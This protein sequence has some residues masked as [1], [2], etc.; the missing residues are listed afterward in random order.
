MCVL[1]NI[2]GVH[3]NQSEAKRKQLQMYSYIIGLIVALLLGGILGSNGT[4]YLTA[5]VAGIFLFVILSSAGMGDAFGRLLRS[6]RSK[7]QY[8]DAGELRKCAVLIQLPAGAAGFILALVFSGVLTE[9]V[10]QVPYAVLPMRILSPV[11]FFSA[12][13]VLL[14]GYFQG[15]GALMPSVTVNFL[16]PVFYLSF[17]YLFGRLLSG[18]GEKVSALLNN[19]DFVGMWGTIGISVGVVVSEFLLL[20]FL[21]LVYLG[22]NRKV[23]REKS[24]EGLQKTMGTAV[25]VRM[26][27]LMRLVPCLILFILLLF[28]AFG[29]G[30][31]ERNAEDIFSAA[32][33]YGNYITGYILLCGIPLFLLLGRLLPVCGRLEALARKKDYKAI[34]EL[35]QAIYHYGWIFC[36]YVTILFVIMSS[37]LAGMLF[38]DTAEQVSS[39]LKVGAAFILIIGMSVC[40]LIH[41]I[42]LDRRLYVIGE[43]VIGF[44]LYA[45]SL[46][47]MAGKGTLEITGLVYAG[48]IGAAGILAAAVVLTILSG[49]PEID[50]LRILGIPLV[51]AVV[52][53]LVML[54]LSKILSPHLGNLMSLIV[55]AIVGLAVDIGALTAVKNIRAQEIALLYG[56][57][58]NRL[59][60]ILTR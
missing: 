23:D 24:G 2:G 14:L 21:F 48:L 30:S 27:L 16:R 49:R 29:L 33:D 60:A 45:V 22:S 50:Y 9:S 10:L 26:L 32:Y 39:M 37:E 42:S 17:G 6:K 28:V 57:L 41:Q 4:T 3:M 46:T 58:G 54:F 11:I 13:Q 35:M 52:A 59:L 25:S 31:Y 40:I 51:A 36:L 47:V 8:R 56:K 5:A 20:I 12:L 44:V 19:T 34:K 38:S 18:Y 43:L 15:A 53:G 55:C 7:G 1:R